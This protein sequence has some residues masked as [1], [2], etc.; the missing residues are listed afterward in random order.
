M[1]SCLL[2]LLIPCRSCTLAIVDLSQFPLLG[3]GPGAPEALGQRGQLPLNV[4]VVLVPRVV[5]V[6]RVDVVVVGGAKCG[7]GA[8]AKGGCGGCGWC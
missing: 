3:P 8:C 1:T 4:V 2:S 5:V 7:G 6:P